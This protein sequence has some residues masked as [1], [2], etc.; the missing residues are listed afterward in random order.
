MTQCA[1]AIFQPCECEVKITFSDQNQMSHAGMGFN[2]TWQKCSSVKPTF[3]LVGLRSKSHFR[4][5]VKSLIIFLVRSSLVHCRLIIFLVG[6]FTLRGWWWMTFKNIF[7]VLFNF[8]IAKN[9]VLDFKGFLRSISSWNP[10]IQQHWIWCQKQLRQ[11]WLISK[12]LLLHMARVMNIALFLRKIQKLTIEDQG[13]NY[14][15]T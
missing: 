9:L 6:S 7:L 4:S 5:K 2:E 8:I 3:S 14:I 13:E 1:E 11:W 15:V 10:M 12:T